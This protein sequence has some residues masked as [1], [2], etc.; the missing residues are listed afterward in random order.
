MGTAR[1]GGGRCWRP[2]L[3]VLA[4]LGLLWMHGLGTHGTVE[5]AAAADSVT[6]AAH[7]DPAASEEDHGGAG[8]HGGHVMA[9]GLCLALLLAAVLLTGRWRRG[10]LLRL[11]DLTRTL[12]TGLA[13][14]A[15]RARP[16]DLVALGV[17]RC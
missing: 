11:R 8:D 17:C 12:S 2:L 5:P 3:V 4:L 14:P 1:R 9:V 7:Q 16:P 15:P 6:H 13:P 10:L